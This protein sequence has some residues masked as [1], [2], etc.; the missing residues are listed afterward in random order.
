MRSLILIALFLGAVCAFSEQE[1]KETFVSWMQKH[2]KSYTSETFQQ[3]FN[4]FKSNMDFVEKW[5][6][7]PTHTHTCA[8]NK[9]ADLSNEEF[10]KTYLGLRVNQT[11]MQERLEAAAKLPKQVYNLTGDNI[12]WADKGAVTGVKDQGQCGSCWSFSTTGSVEALNKIATGNLISLSEQNLI[13]C[14]TQNAGCSGG[15]N[16]VAMQYIIDNRGID[17]EENY[18]Y[19]ARNDNC[20]FNY[21]YTGAVINGIQRGS[22]GDEGALANLVYQQPV[23]IGIDASHNSFQ[24][25]S[26][27]IYYESSCSTS[28][29][30]HAV[31][32]IGFGSQNGD[33]WIVKNSWGT[34]WGMSGY[35]WMARNAGNNCGVATD[36]SVPR[37]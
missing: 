26:N 20:R 31:L 19:E 22:S 14:S 9:F 25:Y 23:S 36:P 24:L 29:L 13:D 15:N 3:R 28:A 6:S 1:Y 35:I 7:D 8:L 18:P 2:E 10:R 4:I 21:A 11:L 34:G 5:N 12:N 16:E 33:Y 37:P 17:R 27:G 30:D 32:I